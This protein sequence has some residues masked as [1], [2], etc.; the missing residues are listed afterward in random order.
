M[1]RRVA[2]SLL[3]AIGLLVALPPAA[4]LGRG[5]LADQSDARGTIDQA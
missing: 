2:A 1:G 3:L 5:R 4:G